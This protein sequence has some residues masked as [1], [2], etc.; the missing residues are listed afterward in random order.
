VFSNRG[1]DSN[2]EFTQKYRCFRHPSYPEW[3]LLHTFHNSH[4]PNLRSL[5]ASGAL[6]TV[7]R[8]TG[9]SDET[10]ERALG[11]GEATLFRKLCA[12]FT[13]EATT[14]IGLGTHYLYGVIGGPYAGARETIMA[15]AKHQGIS[16]LDLTSIAPKVLEALSIRDLVQYILDTPPRCAILVSLDASTERMKKVVTRLSKD[17]LDLR[18]RRV[19]FCLADTTD[20]LPDGVQ[21]EFFPGS[22]DD[23][24]QMLM[25][26]CPAVF[27]EDMTRL[28]PIAEAMTDYSVFQP[29]IWK[30]VATNTTIEDF[31]ST[32]V[33]QVNRRSSVV[34]V[35]STLET[36]PSFEGSWRRS[37]S[38]VRAKSLEPTPDA[39]CCGIHRVIP[40][41]VSPGDALKCIQSALPRD[42]T[43][44]Y[45]ITV[46]TAAVDDHC[47]SMVVSQPTQQIVVNIQCVVD[48]GILSEVCRELR[49]GHR[50]LAQELSQTNV[51]LTC[52]Q[53]KMDVLKDLIV[54]G[55]TSRE[56][57]CES[58]PA[59]CS[60]RTCTNPVSHFSNGRR[61][62]QCSSCIAVGTGSKK[63]RL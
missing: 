61:K 18:F 56:R 16:V 21:R 17:Q 38:L 39:T 25:Y 20:R 34:D 62:K 42:L 13:R 24:L 10:F 14:D 12:L 19:V 40:A 4:M 45:A 15:T 59:K 53:R 37:F 60:K 30:Q 5:V 28:R 49:T 23:K 27:T 50:L 57:S 8:H 63:R 35:Q 46:G 52:L 36:D 2:P 55:G 7:Q 9:K 29:R 31:L 1:P 11:F 43:S 26:R 22:V 54:Q 58:E 48:P 41:G 51:R 3:S 33:F 44:P 47:G 32:L 6:P